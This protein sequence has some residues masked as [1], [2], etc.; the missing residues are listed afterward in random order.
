MKTRIH[1]KRFLLAV[2]VTAS[3][4]AQEP[5]PAPQTDPFAH[6]D[7]AKAAA[8]RTAIGLPH[9]QRAM[10]MRAELGV[11]NDDIFQVINATTDDMGGT[12]VRMQQYYKGVKVET[13]QVI[14]HANARGE[15]APF[16]N[17]LK[18]NINIR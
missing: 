2:A 14:S 7:A 13:G 5:A 6:R 17:A 16:T 12:H 8:A 11:T 15:Y 18:T 1:T 9:L 3:L 10:T 4:L